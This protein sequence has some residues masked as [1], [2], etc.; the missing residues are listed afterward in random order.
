MRQ[1][2][3]TVLSTFIVLN[4]QSFTG[5]RYPQPACWPEYVLQ[6]ERLLP[7]WYTFTSLL[8]FLDQP[9]LSSVISPLPRKGFGGGVWV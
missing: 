2:K 8:G 9:Q 3:A 5:E 7:A 6:L 4:L 1:E